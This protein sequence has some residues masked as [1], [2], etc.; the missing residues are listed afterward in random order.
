[1]SD[2]ATLLDE[3]APSP[4]TPVDVDAVLDRGNRLGRRRTVATTLATVVALLAVTGVVA[5]LAD[6]PDAPVVG[7]VPGAADPVAGTYADGAVVVGAP[8]R[9][10]TLDMGVDEG[11][12][13]ITL[14]TF[15]GRPDQFAVAADGAIGLL[16]GSELRIVEQGE[17]VASLSVTELLPRI[18]GDDVDDPVATTDALLQR[19]LSLAFDGLGVL[20]LVVAGPD[21]AILTLDRTG[22]ASGGGTDL[23]AER[24]RLRVTDHGISIITHSDDAYGRVPAE[25][26]VT[27]V[28]GTDPLA[29]TRPLPVVAGGSFT[30]RGS[31][32]LDDALA[33]VSVQ[34]AGQVRL[35][36]VPPIPS[37]ASR[38]VQALW[39][40][41]LVA[42]TSAAMAVRTGFDHGVLHVY[43]AGTSV[44]VL[45]EGIDATDLDAD[46]VR[47]SVAPDGAVHLARH[48]D[49]TTTVRTL[50]GPDLRPATAD[51]GR[52]ELPAA[53][54]GSAP[55]GTADTIGFDVRL[56]RTL[57]GPGDPPG[58][59]LDEV[60]RDQV[61]TALA[62]VPTDRR[63][64]VG[65][66]LRSGT[67]R[68]V[69]GFTSSLLEPLA[70]DCTG[71]DLCAG[72]YA[73]AVL[74]DAD[75]DI[76]LAHALPGLTGRGTLGVDADGHLVGVGLTM[77]DDDPRQGDRVV[78]RLGTTPGDRTVVVL[79]G[80]DSFF[81]PHDEPV[82]T[83]GVLSPDALPDGWIVAP[84]GTQPPA[85]LTSGGLVS[86]AQVNRL[87]EELG[88]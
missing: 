56:R 31:L 37:Q 35:A 25:A 39:S 13:G 48:E 42:D 55:T 21:G 26:T 2:L 14:A 74:L 78:Y 17:T 60:R 64:S 34:G 85:W 19:D 70:P 67:G 33:T 49:G 45:V 12:D 51:A 18:A 79:P 38:F 6:G 27:E 44:G 24:Q 82:A 16:E 88:G 30:D 65:P 54:D 10:P 46:D 84:R 80:E 61:P 75:G 66:T 52:V 53:A 62:R 8:G 71:P 15:E 81:L 76:V 11:L 1:M 72:Q 83:R 68:W 58:Q 87:A 28:R 40:A 69:Q 47:L 63:V 59:T 50:L 86:A 32:L 5:E 73:E 41:P 57:S 43:R 22:S 23:T 9:S 36:N 77:H 4:R 7:Q 3:A 29:G 20:R